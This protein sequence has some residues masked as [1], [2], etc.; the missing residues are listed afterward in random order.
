LTEGKLRS[1][2]GKNSHVLALTGE[3]ITNACEMSRGNMLKVIIFIAILCIIGMVALSIRKQNKTDNEYDYGKKEPLTENEQIMYWRLV[4]A[5]PNHVVLAQVGMASCLATKSISAHRTI[6]QKSLDFVICNKA[7]RIIAAIEIDDKTHKRDAR[8]KAD[9]TKNRALKKAG[10][11]LIR[12]P[13][14][15]LPTE[16]AIIDKLVSCEVRK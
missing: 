10:I 2:I 1:K 9:E 14:G 7:M 12:W 3:S 11:D 6:A 13:S 5:L 4:K 15:S 16:Q 8:K